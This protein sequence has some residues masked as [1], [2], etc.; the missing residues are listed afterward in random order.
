MP[1]LLSG[2]ST[3]LCA[4]AGAVK[5]AGDSRPLVPRWPLV[6]RAFWERCAHV[7]LDAGVCALCVAPAEGKC[8][9]CG[10]AWHE[11][12]LAAAAVDAD[13]LLSAAWEGGARVCGLRDAAIARER[14]GDDPMRQKT[15]G[16]R[17]FHFRS[18]RACLTSPQGQH[19]RNPMVQVRADGRAPALRSSRG[20]RLS[21]H[22]TER[23]SLLHRQ[24][25]GRRQ[26][27]ACDRRRD[28]GPP[29]RCSAPQRCDAQC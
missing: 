24:M 8:A 15:R 10:E 13:A 25:R 17:G 21:A 23:T 4:R 22:A 18:M 26:P 5:A 7:R 2:T 28:G 20:S 3:L 29:W 14:Q 6:L 16:E 19:A 9:A 12:C 27:R 11:A 1:V